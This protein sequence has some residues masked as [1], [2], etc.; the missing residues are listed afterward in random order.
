MRIA[1]YMVYLCLVLPAVSACQSKKPS[2]TSQRPPTYS[3]GDPIPPAPTAVDQDAKKQLSSWTTW[4]KEGEFPLLPHASFS[5]FGAFGAPKDFDKLYIVHIVD[6]SQTPISQDDPETDKIEIKTSNWFYF[7]Y[8]SDGQFHELLKADPDN[9]SATAGLT[10]GKLPKLYSYKN[11]YVIS[12]SR[13]K[14][15]PNAVIKQP[16][17]KEEEEA[18]S[19]LQMKPT[20]PAPHLEYAA[21]PTEGIAANKGALLALFGAIL[22]VNIPAPS[23]NA[24][25]AP[26]EEKKPEVFYNYEF[27]LLPI[28]NKPLHPPYTLVITATLSSKEKGDDGNCH[29]V[30]EKTACPISQTVNVLDVEHWGIGI[31]VVAYGPV[32]RKYSLDDDNKVQ[33]SSTRHMPLYATFDYSPWATK[34]PMTAWHCVYFQGGL[35]L[36]GAVLHMPYVGIAWPIPGMNKFLPLS[37]Y[38]GYTFMKQTKLNGMPVG[39]VTTPDVFAAAS[40]TDW[41]KKPLYGVEV[42]V[43]AIVS[44]IKS[45]VAK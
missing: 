12:I 43:S 40:K 6:S 41:A 24:H 3:L 7:R 22:N 38:G 13:L 14:L 42:S 28:S 30:K 26:E 4:Q 36:S 9:K 18:D 10:A 20:T 5:D 11:G 2:E 31:N 21:V 19:I 27:Q 33:I 15:N 37:L 23:G 17:G 44:K 8:G 16:L 39:S 32:E 29:D 1:V 34:C 45:S 35:P 25:V